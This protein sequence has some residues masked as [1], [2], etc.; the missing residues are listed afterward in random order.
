MGD[1]PWILTYDNILD[2]RKMYSDVKGWSYELFYSAHIKRRE[3]ELLYASP[4]LKVESYDSVHLMPLKNT[5]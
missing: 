2:V 4:N 1:R 3:S 5:T